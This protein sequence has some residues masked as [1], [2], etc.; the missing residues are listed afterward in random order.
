MRTTIQEKVEEGVGGG[1]GLDG[2][3]D[4]GS[5]GGG[6]G[7]GRKVEPE[8]TPPPE[9][10]RIGMWLTIVSVSMLFLTLATAYV[11]TGANAQRIIMPRVLWLSTGLILT[12]SL[13]ME[14]AR[15][16]LRS[17][18]EG[19]FRLWI[20]TTFA[21]GA[22]FLLAQLWGWKQLLAAGFY[23][24]SNFRSGFAY[25]FTGLHGI[26]LAG[27]LF[28]L[29]YVAFKSRDNWTAIRRRV[30]VDVAAVYWHFLDILWVL[31]LFF[32]FIWGG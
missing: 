16:A 10:Y 15:R 31:M 29:A 12:S 25:I 6:S 13:T 5:G 2:L 19:R 8:K 14:I 21:L 30:S 11:L 7:G 32:I 17:R 26:H 20:N 3:W 9:G 4:G 23:V 24:N 18:L 28:A 1:G 22:G 27:G